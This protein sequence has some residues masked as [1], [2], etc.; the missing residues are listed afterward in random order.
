MNSNEQTQ[1]IRSPI[2]LK[3]DEKWIKL[4]ILIYIPLYGE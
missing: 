4:L 2:I 1:Y 3:H